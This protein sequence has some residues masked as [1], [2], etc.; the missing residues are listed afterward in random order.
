[1]SDNLNLV[2]Y[3]HIHYLHTIRPLYHVNFFIIFEFSEFQKCV[4]KTIKISQNPNN[5]KGFG[6]FIAG[7]S[8]KREPVTVQKVSL[9]MHF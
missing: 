1:M 2:K 7:G 5:S 4:E 6:F 9:G 3:L 8:E